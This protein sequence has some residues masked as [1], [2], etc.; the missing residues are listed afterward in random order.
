MEY[1]R[2]VSPLHKNRYKPMQINANERLSLV[3]AR[4]EL[5]SLTSGAKENTLQ[6][7]TGLFASNWWLYSSFV[8]CCP[9]L[10][11]ARDATQQNKARRNWIHPKIAKIAAFIRC[12]YVTG[13]HFEYLPGYD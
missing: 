11:T 3:A 8:C 4:I 6:M 7:P 2:A 13:T 5:T 10:P 9:S 1:L 12:R